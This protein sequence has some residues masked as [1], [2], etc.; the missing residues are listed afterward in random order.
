MPAKNPRLTITLQPTLAAQLRRLSELT[1]NSQSALIAE[2]L[3]G[4]APIFDRMITLLEAA[5]QAKEAIRGQAVEDLGEAQARLEAQLGLALETWDEV[6]RPILDEAEKV[7]RRA[8]RR[9]A[10]GARGAGAPGARSG[11]RTPPS[12]RG[13]RT[14]P[15]QTKKSTPTRG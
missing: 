10:G 4:S 13:V 15:K 1:G 5:Q 6:A 2:L 8:P 3:E 9:G 14:T 12:N 11:A 7:Q